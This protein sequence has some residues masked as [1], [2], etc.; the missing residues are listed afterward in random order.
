MVY[1]DRDEMDLA[2]EDRLYEQDPYEGAEFSDTFHEQLGETP[3]DEESLSEDEA[4]AGSVPMTEAEPVAGEEFGETVTPGSAAGED[5]LEK[6][7]SESSSDEL[8]EE[9]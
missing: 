8:D 6:E 1:E 5:E 2:E 7:T 4:M 9:R 3:M